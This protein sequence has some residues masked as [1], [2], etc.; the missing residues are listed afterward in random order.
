M[1]FTRYTY[2][3][4]L[5]LILKPAI[6][7]AQ[8]LE[9]KWKLNLNMSLQIPQGKKAISQNEITSPSYF[10]NFNKG[11]GFETSLLYK[12]KKNIWIGIGFNND[13]F[14][15]WENLEYES[16][17]TNAKLS[18]L[19]MGPIV[20]IITPFQK[21]GIF[22]WFKGGVF[23]QPTYNIMKMET[24]SINRIIQSNKEENHNYIVNMDQSNLGANLGFIAE[25]Q[26]SQQV[27][28]FSKYSYNFISAESIFFED[29][30]F[31]FHK[32]GMGITINLGFDKNTLLK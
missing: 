29:K 19:S 17:F 2:I 31:Q 16:Y 30:N 20:Q 21:S 4:L 7:Q 28:I 8:Y 27:C 26:V 6:S 3:I 13:K 22:N 14:K 25:F 15:E 12:F 32:I 11:T 18:N 9:S 24:N 10:S 23:I 5:F 1:Q